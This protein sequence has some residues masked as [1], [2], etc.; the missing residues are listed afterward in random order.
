MIA[1]LMVRPGYHCPWYNSGVMS[2]PTFGALC[3][4]ASALAWSVTSLMARTLI[5][6]YGSVTINAV[7]SGAAGVLLLVLVMAVDGPH[8]LFAMS[9]AT[10]VQLTV[11]IVAIVIARLR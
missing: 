8:T 6:H 11:S 9:G 4:L 10:F 3:A 2:D 5:P 7:R 1:R